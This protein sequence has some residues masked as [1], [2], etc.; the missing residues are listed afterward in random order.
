MSIEE[1]FNLSKDNKNL[2]QLV[3]DQIKPNYDKF[4]SAHCTQYLKTFND[5]REKNITHLTKNYTN[6]WFFRKKREI[7]DDIR[8]L[9]EYDAKILCKP[10]YQELSECLDQIYTN[11]FLP[12]IN[13]SED[14]RLKERFYLFLKYSYVRDINK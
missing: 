13:K 1:I 4:V 8:E 9:I 5:C 12:T 2:S 10:K 14:K 6:P 11:G 3:K 7:T